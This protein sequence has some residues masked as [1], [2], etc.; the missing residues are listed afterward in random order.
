MDLKH[1]IQFVASRYPDAYLVGGCVRDRLL[2]RGSKDFDFVVP[3]GAL[4]LAREIARRFR[5]VFVPLDE[6][7]DTGRV[8]FREPE[9]RFFFVDIA[10][11]NGDTLE[12]DLRRRD[13]TINAIAVRASDWDKPQPEWIDPLGGREDLRR[14]LIRMASPTAFRDDPARMLRAIRFAASLGFTIGDETLRQIREDSP[15]LLRASIERLRDEICYILAQGN[16]AQH[17]LLMDELGLLE[18]LFPPLGPLKGMMQTYPHHLDGFQHTI[19]TLRQLDWVLAELSAPSPREGR[20]APLHHNL[21]ELKVA[22]LEH[23]NQ[24]TAGER[25]RLVILK[26]ATL[27]HDVGKPATLSIDERGI[28]H[29]YGHEWEGAREAAKAVRRLRFSNQEV[30]GV[31]IIVAH[32]MRPALLSREPEVTRRAIYRFFRDTGSWGV[33]ICL[34]ALA[35]HLATWMEGLTPER[36]E[37]RTYVVGMLLEHYFRRKEVIAPPPLVRGGELIKA[38]GLEPGPIV[39]KLLEAVRE[40]QAAG[41]IRTKDEALH[42][43]EKLLRQASTRVG[44]P[45]AS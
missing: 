7:R 8:V 31:G 38:L 25:N 24:K 34:L 11:C 10:R 18:Q 32:H 9:G 19:E 12:E 5:G 39:G 16:T 44:E 42:L 29:F 15:L 13:F 4:E 20:A 22:I 6:E 41:E 28:T 27:L 30:E 33:E 1:I 37:R 35:D 2:G 36:W 23:I 21:G 17:I 3:Q 45:P 40:A 14:K 43:A 26:L